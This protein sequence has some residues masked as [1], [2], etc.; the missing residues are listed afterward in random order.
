MKLTIDWESHMKTLLDV[1]QCF[2]RAS[3]TLNLNK[4]DIDE[5]T[6]TN[7][8]KEADKIKL[9]STNNIAVLYSPAP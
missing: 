5:A 4:C 1:F 6:T 3:L 7:L 2:E 9:I 8:I